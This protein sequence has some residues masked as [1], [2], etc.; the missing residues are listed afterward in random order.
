MTKELINKIRKVGKNISILYVEDDLAIALEVTK[1]LQKVFS[2]ID[3]VENG[4]KA[5]KLFEE[6]IYDIVITDIRLPDIDGLELAEKIKEVAPE[7]KVIIISAYDDVRYLTQM[8]ELGIDKFILKPI[9]MR[10]FFITISKIVVGIYNE[11]RNKKLEQELLEKLKMKEVLLQ[12][13]LTPIGVFEKNELTY[14]NQKFQDYFNIPNELPLESFLLSNLF[15]EEAFSSLSNKELLMVLK[16]NNGSTR[17]L[18]P[19]KTD[20]QQRYIINVTFI[21][22]TSSTLVCFFNVERITSELDKLQHQ[23]PNELSTGLFTRDQFLQHLEKLM[24]N[25]SNQ[26]TITC[27]GIKRKRELMKSFGVASFYDIYQDTAN[28]LKNTFSNELESEDVRLYYFGLN[29]F[30]AITTHQKNEI[31]QNT[32][33]DFAHSNSFTDNNTKISEPIFFD[34]LSFE[35]NKSSTPA[36]VLAN[37]ENKLYMLME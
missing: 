13:M 19:F 34:I 24:F 6:N 23:E 10:Q 11:K 28:K 30:V 37:A 1:L 2:K 9:N 7:Q 14:V 21:P 3:T 22:D 35:L 15:N 29:Q 20:N 26:Y 27:F 17:T 8:I 12:H 32:L 33:E 4:E 31:V 5:L 36:N 18:H 16:Q 25:D